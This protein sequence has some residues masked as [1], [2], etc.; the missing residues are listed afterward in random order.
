MAHDPVPFDPSQNSLTLYRD[1]TSDLE[2]V[3]PGPPRRVDGWTLGVA[4]MLPTDRAHHGGERH[5]DGDEVVYIISG[6]VTLLL[7]EG[8]DERT[9]E[10]ATGQASVIPR[11]VWHRLLVRE[12]TQV[13]FV[14]PGPGGDWRPVKDDD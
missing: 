11:G 13:L 2:P 5:P 10:L 1:G 4:R 12:P 14:T 7:D 8:G 3:G 6:R 9:V